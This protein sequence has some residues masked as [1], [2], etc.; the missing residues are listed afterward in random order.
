MLVIQVT[1]IAFWFTTL[2]CTYVYTSLNC[3][4]HGNTALYWAAE[5]GHVEV[6]KLLLQKTADVSI[7]NKVHI[8]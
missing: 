1:M 3:V 5:E 7:E 8:L 2:S 6:V 4:Q